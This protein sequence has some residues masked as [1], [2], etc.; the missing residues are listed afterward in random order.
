MPHL[1][2]DRRVHHQDAR[3]LHGVRRA[4][5]PHQRLVAAQAAWWWAAPAPTRRAAATATSLPPTNGA[6][7]PYRGFQMGV[8][9]FR[10]PDL[11]ERE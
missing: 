1:L 2:A 6:E 10:K 3:H 9:V 5:E 8:A 11:C 7:G 4:G